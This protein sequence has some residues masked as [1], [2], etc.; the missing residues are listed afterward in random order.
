VH[1]PSRR[2]DR[3]ATSH[4]RD[5]RSESM[6]LLLLP[7]LSLLT[8]L[9][10]WGTL[11]APLV[12]LAGSTTVAIIAIV[13]GAAG[14][15]WLAP[16][17]GGFMMGLMTGAQWRPSLIILGSGIVVGL[18]LALFY[19]LEGADA[20]REEL[21]AGFRDAGPAF[22]LPEGS[23]TPEQL[24]DMAIT[25]LPSF[26]VIMVVAVMALSYYIA[27]RVL[28]RFGFIVPPVAPLIYWRLPFAVV[29]S[30]VTALLLVAV[31]WWMNSSPL[32]IIG[33][34]LCVLLG[35]AFFVL[36]LAVVRFTLVARGVPERAQLVMAVLL[37]PLMIAVQ[38]QF[39]LSGVG[40]FDMW[41]DFRKLERATTTGDDPHQSE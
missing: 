9:V 30:L 15:H 5:L 17:A 12:S 27:G 26:T 23:L 20:L 22:Q 8:V 19:Q 14:A 29:W 11:R 40:L 3:A 6:D 1:A 28:P 39:V 18:A 10:M 38:L 24:V 32:K 7:I 41:F 37:V 16:V 25:L 36:G 13:N 4:G 35:A 34:N 33:G 21:L 31:G 2:L